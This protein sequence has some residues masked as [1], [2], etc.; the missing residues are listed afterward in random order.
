MS[1]NTPG[2]PQG[3]YG[4]TQPA[5]PPTQYGNTNPYA[6]PPPYQYLPPY[7]P[8]NNPPPGGVFRRYGVFA[9]IV[10][11][12]GI[13]VVLLVRPL[14]TSSPSTPPATVAPTATVPLSSTQPVVSQITPTPVA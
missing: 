13:I 12:I 1:S 14:Q 2:S 4:P 10:L 8:A 11:L 5:Q 3:N 7:P 9:F 6:P